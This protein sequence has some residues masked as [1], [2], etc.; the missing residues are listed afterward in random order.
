M[1]LVEKTRVPTNVSFDDFR[2]FA[3][4]T[5]CDEQGRSYVKL[6]K[7]GP[8]M[9]GPLLRLSAKG[10]LE[11]EFDTSGAITNLYATRPNGGVTMVYADQ[12]GKFVENFAPD[13]NR[14]SA[15]RLEPPPLPFFPMQIAVFRS[16][17]ILVAGLQT[18]P[19][20]KASTAVYDPT[21]HLIKQFA[22]DG[23]E[24][25]ERAI[26]AGD[27]RYAS[28]PGRGGEWVSRSLAITGDDG[29]VYLMRATSPTTVYAIS[30]AGEVLR[31]I[32]VS[33]PL[34]A[35]LPN[36]GIRVVKNKLAVRFYRDCGSPLNFRSCHGAVYTVVDATTGKTLAAYE[37]ED[38]V[39]GPLACYDPDPDRFSTFDI[40]SG[41]HR[42]EIVETAPK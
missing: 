24:E 35:G 6:A 38:G 5:L 19:G 2:S 36:F 17:D 34:G 39:G 3:L 37:P 9:V 13:G 27:P 8:G 12:T 20:Y 16:G 18:H 26:K 42:L 21:G 25:I 7:S 14:E 31:K 41:R 4:P 10:Q 29:L 11:A 15:I 32:V 1:V 28:A 23:D 33:S 30:A 22:L 40:P